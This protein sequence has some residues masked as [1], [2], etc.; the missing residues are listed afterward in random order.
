FFALVI[1]GLSSHISIIEAVTSAF[2]DKLNISRKAAASLVCGIGFVVSMSF[3]TNGGLLLLDLV[4]YF[5]NN[6]A[7]LLSCLI[8]LLI[9]GWIIKL[10]DIHKHVNNVSE[11]TIGNWFEICLRFISPLFLLVIVGT[12]I[13]TTLMEGYGGY[14]QSDL[15]LLGWGLVGA[16]F[17]AAILINKASK[18]T[19]QQES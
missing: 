4:D 6:I 14:S 16:M 17:V 1:A 9:M 5:M 8:E 18:N 15:M 10:S 13:Y 11:F 2:I 7:L 19:I 12:N 3:A